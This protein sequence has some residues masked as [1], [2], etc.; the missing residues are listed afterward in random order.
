MAILYGPIEKNVKEWGSYC[1]MMVITKSLIF[2]WRPNLL[3][4]V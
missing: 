3:I 2:S 1:E 4:T